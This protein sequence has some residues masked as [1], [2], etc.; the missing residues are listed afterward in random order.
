MQESPFRKIALPI[1][2]IS[3][4]MVGFSAWQWYQDRNKINTLTLATASPTGEYYAFGKA[5]AKVVEEHNPKI[6]IN[7]IPS[8]GS[9][10][11][12]EWLREKKVEL[13]IVQS[14]TH[15]SPSIDTVSFLFP[16]VFH[17][18]VNRSSG[19]EQFTDLKGKKMALMPE[20]SGSYGLFWLLADHYG[21]KKSDL[22]AMPLYSKQATEK[23]LT[24]EADGFFQVIAL[25]NEKIHDLLENEQLKL[26]PIEQGAA[27]QLFLPALEENL[28]PMG[29]YNGATP[30]PSQDLSTVGVRSVLIT[31][32]KVNP[33][34]I[35]EITRIIHEERNDLIRENVQGAMIPPPDSP[36][37][38]GFPVHT[39]ANNYYDQGNPSF[40]VEYAEPISLGISVGV[41][42]ISGLWQFRM[43]LK[44]KQKNRA[45]LY[46]LEL[47]PLIN[48]IEKSE[49]IEKLD[50]IRKELLKILEEVINDLDKDK[51]TPESFQSFTF[52]L[53]V[54]LTT[55]RHRELLLTELTRDQ[56]I[57][58]NS[59]NGGSHS[60]SLII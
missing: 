50:E 29:T 36:N 13:A 57:I 4:I 8:E 41:L 27:L 25:G 33:E 46:N 30:I 24:G 59:S 14:D 43:W 11:N 21:L 51:I 35:Y 54:A 2:A 44:S 31:H 10:Q 3:L 34:L 6:R 55:I 17:L 52:P 9:Q 40:I 23:L 22:T 56:K 20:G 60:S 42:I 37:R 26:I 12:E 16:E 15:L 7:V 1:V 18:I 32:D 28:I 53:N 39:G 19:I 5:L 38:L 58:D 48:Q 49:T 45:D 47:L